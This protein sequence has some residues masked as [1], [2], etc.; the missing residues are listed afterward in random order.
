MGGEIGL[1]LPVEICVCL[2]GG[3]GCYRCHLALLVMNGG[4]KFS[5]AGYD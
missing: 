2:V 5:F 4:F 3:C 1:I